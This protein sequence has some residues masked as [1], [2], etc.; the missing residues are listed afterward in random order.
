[1]DL[2]FFCL[3]IRMIF[4]SIGFVGECVGFADRECMVWYMLFI[5]FV[6]YAML[7]LPLKWCMVGGTIS[8]TA[9]LIFMSLEKLEK[10]SVSKK[11]VRKLN[12]IFKVFEWFESMILFLWNY[13]FLIEYF[14][15]FRLHRAQKCIIWQKICRK[16]GFFCCNDF[17][18]IRF[19]NIILFLHHRCLQSMLSNQW[20]LNRW[21]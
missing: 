9:H 11:I 20:N 18:F 3:K 16:N 12:D 5:I 14:R 19:V 4:F 15:L 21:N 17:K 6:P 10:S 1:M 7:P 13:I 2:D 8:G